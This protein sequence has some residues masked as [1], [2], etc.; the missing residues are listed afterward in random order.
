M[1]NPPTNASFNA[2]RKT[3][4]ATNRKIAMTTRTISPDVMVN[5]FLLGART[6]RPHIAHRRAYAFVSLDFLR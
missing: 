1:T 2:K 5:I 3:R 4:R 6:A